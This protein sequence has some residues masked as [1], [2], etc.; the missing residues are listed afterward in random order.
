LFSVN[1]KIET[2]PITGPTIFGRKTGRTPQRKL[3]YNWTAAVPFYV[4]A[5]VK[6]SDKLV[7]CGPEKIIDEKGV[8]S[9]YPEASVLEELKHQDAILD[10]E[11]GSHLWVVRAEDGRVLE[12]HKLPAVP[13]W[14]GMAAADGRVFLATQDGVVCLG[15]EKN[16][17]AAEP[18]DGC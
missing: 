5:M 2:E 13:V 16:A 11:E 12:K 1:K 3:R 17:A 4:R 7:L 18:P 9:R 14:D 15:G 8:I 6:A 10:G